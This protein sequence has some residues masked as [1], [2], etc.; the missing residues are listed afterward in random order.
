MTGALEYFTKRELG[1]MAQALSTY[2]TVRS[3]H[4]DNYIPI[5]FETGEYDPPPPPERRAWMK[6]DL[7]FY[8]EY[9]TQQNK[10]FYG[11]NAKD[12][13]ET[14]WQM[15]VAE[16]RSD[17]LLIR[18]DS[19]LK[20]LKEGKLVDPTGE[21][22]PNLLPV[23]LNNDPAAKKEVYD[24]VCEW[25]DSEE[26]AI[27][28]L[29]HV[30]MALHPGW[31][32]VRRVLLVG[33]GRNGK[34]VFM[35]MLHLALGK[36]NCSHV[37]RKQMDTDTQAPLA[38]GDALANIVFDAQA[39]TIR[40][41]STEKTILA[42]EELSV[43]PNHARRPVLI[44]TNAMHIEGMNDEPNTWDKSFAMDARHVRF[45]FPNTYAGSPLFQQKMESDEMVGAFLALM[46]DHMVDRKDVAVMLAPTER[47]Q[48]LARQHK[49]ANDLGARFI[50]E[51]F[52]TAGM[53]AQRLRGYGYKA[54][55]DRFIS[56]RQSVDSSEK[57]DNYRARR[58]LRNV[59]EVD[60]R[61]MLLPDG[62]GV[63]V[64]QSPVLGLKPDIEA[65]IK[66]EMDSFE[67]TI[68]E[69]LED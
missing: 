60:E 59:V 58:V 11:N 66:D 49:L 17:A 69:N 3:V 43:R 67:D 68:I 45:N 65:L 53:D 56:W 19:G 37:T 7:A 32:A 18:T 30:S 34:G 63:K 29:R 23:P 10:L 13:I 20:M 24:I 52:M 4:P 38:F 8:V 5:D 31:T 14:V 42:G 46:I 9:V 33:N 40:D 62:N 61:R 51:L 54:L 6:M 36:S 41:T 22:V 57:W 28:L 1:Q 44:S 39:E 12:F 16:P 50:V 25:V 48:V 26:E 2:R 27:S 47:S 64:K 35:R 21:F 15:S 55:C